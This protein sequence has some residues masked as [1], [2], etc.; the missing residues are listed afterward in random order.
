MFNMSSTVVAFTDG[1]AILNNRAGYSVYFASGEHTKGY[2]LC[3]HQK[4]TVKYKATNQRAEGTAFIKAI[5]FFI[6]HCT[7]ECKL[8]II[9][10]SEFWKNMIEKYMPKWTDSD[11]SEKKN[12]DLTKQLWKL[13]NPLVKCNRLAI[14][15]MNSHDKNGWSKYPK[16]SREYK[17]YVGNT[18]ADDVATIAR[19]NVF[20]ESHVVVRFTAKLDVNLN[21][22]NL[23]KKLSSQYQQ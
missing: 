21:K 13:A 9:T 20:N 16:Q 4:N 8:K 11:F 3:G 14:E 19:D 15:H 7:T 23:I 12:S 22:T 2:V 6:E 5:E 10:D 18:I 17:L 1:G